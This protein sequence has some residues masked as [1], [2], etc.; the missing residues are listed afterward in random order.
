MKED[1]SMALNRAAIFLSACDSYDAK[2]SAE[3]TESFISEIDGLCPANIRDGLLRAMMEAA[4]EPN[5]WKPESFLSKLI[6]LTISK[7]RLQ[8]MQEE[9]DEQILALEGEVMP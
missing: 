5:M 3:A 6:G 7:I 2:V 1:W 8:A 4:G 9:L